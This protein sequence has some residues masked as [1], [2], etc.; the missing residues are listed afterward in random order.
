MYT[1]VRTLSAV[2]ILLGGL[3][4]L[5]ARS[6][7]P[8]P[9]PNGV[10]HPGSADPPG[11]LTK[12]GLP[13]ETGVKSTTGPKSKSPPDPGAPSQR[14]TNSL[15]SGGTTGQGP[16]GPFSA[17]PTVGLFTG[18][19]AALQRDGIDVHGI[20]LDRYL[21]DTT[22][23]PD[24]HHDGNITAIAPAADFDLEKLLGIKGGAFHTQFTFLV[25]RYDEPNLADYAGGWLT[26]WQTTPALSGEWVYPSLVTYEQKLL[27]NKLSIEFGRTNFFRYFFTP[28]ALDPFFNISA[29]AQVVG[30]SSSVPFPTWGARAIY[31]FTPKYWVQLGAF[32][33]YDYGSDN[34]PFAFG[35]ARAPGASIFTEIGSRTEFFNSK[36]PENFELGVEYSTRTGYSY[37]KGSPLPEAA[38]FSAA[39]YPGG[40]FVFF[41]G[42]QTLWRG[43]RK[44]FGPPANIALYGSV[45][46][47][48]DKPQPFDIDAILGLN[49]NGF[50]PGRPFDAVG[51]Q[52]HY[53]RLSA[54]EA[55]FES[56]FHNIFAGP[57]P[58]QPRNNY[59]FDATYNLSFNNVVSLKPSLQYFVNPDNFGNP[60][61]NKRPGDGFE[62]SVELVV[63]LGR[64]LG[65]SSKP[66]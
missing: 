41:Q 18:T 40:G 38:A 19:G 64:L 53:L 56:K 50:V 49:F 17:A 26:G 46:P 54:V 30:D 12:P 9:Q 47:S 51:F 34:E 55:A 15:L 7:E 11:L 27:Q 14:A 58:N 45:D 6:D 35:A 44:V 24:P 2:A 20:I 29:V 66:F 1:R 31:H 61:F 21:A 36:Y 43:P 10:A 52:A 57:G 33:D 65:T 13:P 63:A 4:P 3:I 39:N 5:Q 59:A 48:Y 62:V 60:T 32:E 8:S 25:G 28:N 42:L 16:P 22:A 23:G 37:T